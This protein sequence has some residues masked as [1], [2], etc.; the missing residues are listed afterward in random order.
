MYDGVFQRAWIAQSRFPKVDVV[1]AF[2]GAAK[3]AN[4]SKA[5]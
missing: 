5:G 3:L 4:D 1:S 2:A